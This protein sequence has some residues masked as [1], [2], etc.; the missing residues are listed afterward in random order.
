[1]VRRHSRADRR[2]RKEPV[3]NERRK[4]W[5][6]PLKIHV[7]RNE[8]SMRVVIENEVVAENCFDLKRI[9]EQKVRP[10]QLDRLVVDLE[11]VPYIDSVGLGLLVDLKGSLALMG[12]QFFVANPH[13]QVKWL[14]ETMSLTK[15]L[16]IFK[17]T[18]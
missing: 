18:P 10:Y 8:R 9:I 16:P 6:A 2:Q 1:M 14:I 13:D 17:D 3:P 15:V 7:E 12:I 4:N 11:S 5:H